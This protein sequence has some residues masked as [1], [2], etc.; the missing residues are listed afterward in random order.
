MKLDKKI[1]LLLGGITVGL[2]FSLGANAYLLKEVTD[3]RI[4]LDSQFEVIS[5]IMMMLGFE[6]KTLPLI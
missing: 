6:L 1:L 3:I 2:L 4:I 5:N